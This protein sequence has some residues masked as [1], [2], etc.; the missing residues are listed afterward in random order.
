MLLNLRPAKLVII[1]KCLYNTYCNRLRTLYLIVSC[2]TLPYYPEA[3]R[4]CQVAIK[5][6]IIAYINKLLVYFHED[7]RLNL[8]HLENHV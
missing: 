5:Q 6:K 8:T 7:I 2:L 1:N 4:K 3:Y